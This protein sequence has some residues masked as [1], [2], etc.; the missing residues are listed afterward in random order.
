MTTIGAGTVA[1]A[2]N[3]LT[4]TLTPPTV[5]P[6]G[7]T[8]AI[9]VTGLTNTSTVGTY[10][11]TVTTADGSTA[12]DTGTTGVVPIIPAVATFPTSTLTVACG[13]PPGGCQAP[14]AGNPASLTLVAVPGSTVTSTV[15]LSVKSNVADGYRVRAQSS[16]FVRS[17][18]G[19]T[20]PEAPSTGSATQPVGSFYATASLAG[21]GVSGAALCAP[22]GSATPYVGYATTPVSLWN[23]TAPTGSGTD[24]VTLTNGIDVPLTQA[25]GTYTS[26]IAYTVTPATTASST[27]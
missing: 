23:A 16:G 21:S 18:G 4:Y 26:T 10:H 19:P 12:V 11:S 14:S 17:G 27:C 24:T 8:V 13:S 22:Y 25:A 6:A 15:A 9:T 1:L 2:T 5:V 20:L 7:A 3:V